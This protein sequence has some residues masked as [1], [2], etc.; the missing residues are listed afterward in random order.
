MSTA[1]GYFRMCG[2]LETYETRVLNYIT[3]DRYSPIQIGNSICITHPLH[4]RT[5]TAHLSSWHVKKGR[6]G[7]L[8]SLV[9][10]KPRCGETQ[11]CTVITHCFA[12]G[13]RKGH[14]SAR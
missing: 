12:P 8:Q 4:R 11:N 14:R 5:N 2:G 10:V 6:C 7:A 3:D 9:V 13:L 1:R